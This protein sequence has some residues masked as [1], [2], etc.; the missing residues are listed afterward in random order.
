M[1]QIQ[2]NKFIIENTPTK[3]RIIN[4]KAHHL[5]NFKQMYYI[6][7]RLKTSAFISKWSSFCD[8]N[9]VYIRECGG[10]PVRNIEIALKLSIEFNKIILFNKAIN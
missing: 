1:V 4:L 5:F 8:F 2:R 6:V 3:I 7:A 9:Y 10:N